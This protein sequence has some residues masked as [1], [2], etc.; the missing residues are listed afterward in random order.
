MDFHQPIPKLFHTFDAGAPFKECQVCNR[1]LIGYDKPYIIEKAIR[2]Y[3]KFGTEDV[4]FEY[5]ICMDC[6]E[7][8]RQQMSTESMFRMEAYWTERFNPAEHLQHS[9]SVPLEYLMDRCA[10]TGERRSQMEEYQIAALCQGSSLVPGQPPY[11]VGGVAMEEIMDL[12][13]NETMD[14][15]NRFRDDFLGPSPEISDLLKG[16]PVLI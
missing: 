16:R 3:P 9:D 8:Q 15:W 12:M 5:A 7:E 10:L 4:V 14:Q 11:I 13:S 6:A 1:D 2:R